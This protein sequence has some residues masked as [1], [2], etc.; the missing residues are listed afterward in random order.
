[1]KSIIS[2]EK[3]L[4]R[5]QIWD[6]LYEKRLS[7]LSQ[8]DYHKIPYFKGAASAAERLTKTIEWSK[9]QNIFCSPDS[10]QKRSGCRADPPWSRACPRAVLRPGET[11]GCG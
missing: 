10:A 2:H 8:G 6:L 7:K 3:E 1:M 11:W 4:I 5:K 9:C